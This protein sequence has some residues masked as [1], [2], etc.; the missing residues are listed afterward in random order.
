VLLLAAGLALGGY[1]L[2]LAWRQPAH[3]TAVTAPPAPAAITIGA[4]ARLP[5]HADFG[6]IALAAN[7]RPDRAPIRLDVRVRNLPPEWRPP[8]A[9]VALYAA[10]DSDGL[11]WLPF[12]SGTA[13]DGDFEFATL[14]ERAGDV[15]VSVALSRD[16]ALHGYLARTRTTVAAGAVVELDASAAKVAFRAR[17]GAGQTG[18]FRIAR[19]DDPHWLPID[20]AVAGLVVGA[21]PTSL[22]LGRGDYV[23]RDTLRPD[24]QQAFT[25]PTDQVVEIS[26]GLARARAD[27]P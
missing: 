21:T 10:D 17:S 11:T 16:A 14:H 23:L 8:T 12:A 20:V 6:R 2:L 27:R 19:V 26:D 5:A 4:P 1:C 24:R 25:V 3:A 9:G 7:H 15:V 22:W 18:P 13:R